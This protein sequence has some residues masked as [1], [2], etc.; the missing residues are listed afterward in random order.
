MDSICVRACGRRDNGDR[1][2]CYILEFLIDHNMKLWA[3]FDT[4]SR[5]FGSTNSQIFASAKPQC[6]QG[7]KLS[8]SAYVI[9]VR[10]QKGKN[11]S[12]FIVWIK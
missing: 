6:L 9:R 4:Q 1:V 7:A 11:E 5:F 8:C 2:N 12:V 10:E 3:V